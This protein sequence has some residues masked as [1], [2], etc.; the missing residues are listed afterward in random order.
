[1]EFNRYIKT[2]SGY[3]LDVVKN[4]IQQYARRGMATKMLE[5]VS[6]IDGFK[7]YGDG[8]INMI[9]LLKVI[10]FED[11]SFSQ[12]GAFTTVCEKIKKWEEDDD[13]KTL[14]EIVAIIAHAKKLRMPTHL[15]INYNIDLISFIEKDDFLEG[16]KD[17]D[18]SVVQWIYYHE[19]EAL[20]MLDDYEFPGKEYILPM[21]KAEWKRFT[22]S[23]ERFPF[24]VVP[25]LWIIFG[26]DLK[27][28][29]G[30]DAPSFT[31]KEIEA[32]YENCD[33]QFEDFVYDEEIVLENDDIEWHP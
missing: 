20:E 19:E 9:N 30:A 25:W 18:L 27:K 21:C 3:P 32:A 7:I 22:G 1:M 24:I 12:V 28:D 29:E 31:E 10:L 14:A 13:E 11:V 26:D 16:I 6:E 2:E 4:A 15:E 8:R 17:K 5:A 33:V 23:A